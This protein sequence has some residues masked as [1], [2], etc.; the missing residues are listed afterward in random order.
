M[1]DDLIIRLFQ[2]HFAD[3]IAAVRRLDMHLASVVLPF[4]FHALLRELPYSPQPS[5]PNEMPSFTLW[6]QEQLAKQ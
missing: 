6:L 3:P 4:D 1:N 5:L 2:R